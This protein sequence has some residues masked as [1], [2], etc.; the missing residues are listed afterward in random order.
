MHYRGTIKY[1]LYL[2]FPLIPPTSLVESLI[3]DDNKIEKQNKKHK[4]NMNVLYVMFMHTEYNSSVTLILLTKKYYKFLL[5]EIS[6]NSPDRYYKDR[7][8]FLWVSNNWNKGYPKSLSVGY[9]LLPGLPCLASV[10]EDAPSL[11][12]T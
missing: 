4:L 9:V 1:L 10:K 5:N 11:T 6:L 8:V 3:Q 2:G 7:L 12:E